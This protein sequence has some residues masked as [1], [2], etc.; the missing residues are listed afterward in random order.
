MDFLRS[1]KFL[2]KYKR[3]YENPKGDPRSHVF[4]VAMV[5]RGK[6]PKMCGWSGALERGVSGFFT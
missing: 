5:V 1:I 3:S 6:L 2:L 4:L